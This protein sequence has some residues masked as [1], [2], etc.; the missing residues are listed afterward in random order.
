CESCGALFVAKEVIDGR[1]RSLYRRRFCLDCSPFGTHHTSRMPPGGLIGAELAEHRRRKRNAKAYRYQ[2]KRRKVVKVELVSAHG[3]RC[4]DCGYAA[5][6]AALD[7][8]HRVASEKDFAISAFGGSWQKLRA[9]AQK[10][11]LVCATCH[12]LR[13]AIEDAGVEG[14]PVVEH[15]RARKARAVAFMGGEC[16]GC[17]RDGPPAVFDFHHWDPATKSF[18]IGQDGIP[19]RWSKIAAELAKCVMLCANCHRE[20]HA[21]VR[22]LDGGLLGLVEDALRYAA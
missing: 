19:R 22:E 5:S 18:G 13:H 7:F 10:C 14:G 1:V 11:D 8:H 9:E 2:R 4:V 15:R 12:R 17:G 21:G 16:H 6:V 3:G 20:V